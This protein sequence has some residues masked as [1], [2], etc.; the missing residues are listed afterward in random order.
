VSSINNSPERSSSTNSGALRLTGDSNLP[1]A[2]SEV[3]RR[4]KPVPHISVNKTT[5]K[6]Q[7]TGLTFSEFVKSKQE[8]KEAKAE[9]GKRKVQC[10]P[11]TSSM[12]KRKSF[13][14]KKNVGNPEVDSLLCAECWENY[15]TTRKEKL[16][17]SMF[18]VFKMAT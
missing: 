12:N 1:L 6:Q 17:D 9:R 5:E 7:A 2:P 10:G 4:I 14:L 18:E 16:L 3:L 11:E 13:S 15:Y 8:L